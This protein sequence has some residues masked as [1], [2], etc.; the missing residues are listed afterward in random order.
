[1]GL[2]CTVQTQSNWGLMTCRL[3]P[4]QPWHSFTS[5]CTLPSFPPTRPHLPTSQRPHPCF[6]IPPPH[7]H[8][9]ISL[10]SQKCW[11]LLFV[12]YI[13]IC[14]GHKLS[15]NICSLEWR[16]EEARTGQLCMLLR[17]KGALI[18]CVMYGFM[19]VWAHVHTHICVCVNNY[20]NR[21]FVSF[22]VLY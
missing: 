6:V 7:P 9:Q 22:W 3:F 11:V 15:P 2:C 5:L 17:G 1:M 19:H 12:E 18:R 4:S 8:E 16:Q 10:C 21:Y 14:W 13:E 20:S